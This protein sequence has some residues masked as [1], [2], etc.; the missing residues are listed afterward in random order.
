M[1]VVCEWEKVEVECGCKNGEFEPRRDEHDEEG[2]LICLDQWLKEFGA[3][4]V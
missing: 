2:V 4:S 3:K 1:E